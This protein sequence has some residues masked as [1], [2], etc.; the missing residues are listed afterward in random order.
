MRTIVC[1]LM[2]ALLLVHALVG[3]CHA[4]ELSA[5][6]HESQAAE[7]AKNRGASVGDT[8]LREA[9]TCCHHAHSC[10]GGETETVP[11]PCDCKV[12]CKSLC[13]YLP[14]EKCGVD[15]GDLSQ[16]LDGVLDAHAGFASALVR[17]MIADSVANRSAHCIC[18]K[19]PM[20]LH[21]WHQMI[22]I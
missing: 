14:P 21:L 3:C 20:R 1:N 11:S 9:G 2:S 4:H 18:W 22:L 13:I 7:A 8:G 19:P 10:C 12:E 6:H 15:A 16:T 17:L 5:A